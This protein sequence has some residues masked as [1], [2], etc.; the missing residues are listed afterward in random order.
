MAP[1][2]QAD[3][4]PPPRR[5]P[6]PDVRSRHAAVPRPTP[7]RPLTTP[8]VL[9]GAVAIIKADPRTVLLISALFVVP[10]QVVVAYLQR[11]ALGGLGFAEITSDPSLAGTAGNSD[12]SGGATLV[13][14]VGGSLAL[15]LVAAAIARLVS[16]WYAGAPPTTGQA[17]ARTARRAPVLVLVW[18]V[19]HAAELVGAVLL[20]LPALGVM[21][22]FVVTAPVVG[23]EDVGPFAALARS[24]RLVGRR[25]WQV[26]GTA[27]LIGVVG[28]VLTQTLG[29]LP[30]LPVLFGFEAAW[31]VVAIGGSAVSLFTT[32][33]VAAAT[34]LLYLDLRVRV[35]GL[36]IELRALDVLDRAA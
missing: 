35:E 14:F 28:T 34:V 20:F 24:A 33:Y 36:D 13:A 16:G 21:T 18:A 11:D 30:T 31:V 7:L 26:L 2:A 12:S 25:F 22:I 1:E 17:L 3:V 9:D 6:A 27:L 23:V 29:L 4:P 19:V 8:D 15:N 32:A 5:S 10:V